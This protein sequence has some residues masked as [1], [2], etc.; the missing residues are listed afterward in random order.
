MMP[1]LQK[2]DSMNSLRNLY[3]NGIKA[4]GFT[5]IALYAIPTIIRKYAGKDIIGR[6]IREDELGSEAGFKLGLTI[7]ILGY[8]CLGINGSLPEALLIPVAS[9]FIFGAYE[10]VR[11][12]NEENLKKQGT[13]ILEDMLSS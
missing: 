3:S 2:I 7:H 13:R 6:K 12:I 9:N 1:E 8:T 5:L 11:H 4:A 10:I